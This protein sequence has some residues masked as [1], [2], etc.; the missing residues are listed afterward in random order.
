ME[1]MQIRLS[2]MEREN[3]RR[4]VWSR[5]DDR[6]NVYSDGDRQ[7]NTL[8]IP[9]QGSLSD[10]SLGNLTASLQP[11]LV[12]SMLDSSNTL[13][14][15]RLDPGCRGGASNFDPQALSQMVNTMVHQ[16]MS[17]FGGFPK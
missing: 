9:R 5:P 2:H 7:D 17:G 16:A 14:D 15:P 6:S 8:G 1:S 3:E 10:S 4:D 12:P 11:N 13:M